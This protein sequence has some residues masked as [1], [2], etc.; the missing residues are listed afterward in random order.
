MG[1]DKSDKK[2]KSET[3]K[4]DKSDKKDKSAKK[5]AK[6]E[7]EQKEAERKEAE[8]KEAERKEAERKEAEKKEA[9]KK[10]LQKKKSS[11]SSGSDSGDSSSGSSSSDDTS[12]SESGESSSGSDT[13]SGS[14]SSDS[15]PK[16]APNQFKRKLDNPD[17]TV[18]SP[19]K[20]Q[21][22]NDYSPSTPSKTQSADAGNKIFIAN[23][24]DTVTDDLTT[25][26]FKSAG[27]IT[28]ISW[29]T[30]KDTGNFKG[31][32]FIEFATAEGAA[33]AVDLN[34]NFLEGK[35]V[36]VELSK[37]REVA[38]NWTCDACGS[39]NWPAKTA[40]FKRDCG[41]PKPGSSGGNRG[42]FGGGGRGG[43][44]N[45]GGFGG[46]GGRGGG[47]NRGSFGGKESQPGD[48]SCEAC[49]ANNFARNVACFKRECGAPRK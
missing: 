16:E 34:G 26:F 30:H 41:A 18:A 48:W 13:S 33:K 4:K 37:P 32:G 44:G 43:G 15:A 36:R 2:A 14:S 19:A 6:K 45:R 25:E 21:K 40:C 27:E 1:K 17:T 12:D 35:S 22:T 46:G 39:S 38:E 8:R 10:A 49:G 24:S 7:A 11:S 5:A 31:C 23:V 20:I 28:K 42:G 47:G 9:E 29:L 3:E